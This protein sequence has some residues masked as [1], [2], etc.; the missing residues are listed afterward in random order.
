MRH[1]SRLKRTP[2]VSPRSVGRPLEPEP[3]QIPVVEALGWR[4]ASALGGLTADR[5]T[6][7][8][9]DGLGRLPA[10]D[11]RFRYLEHRQ[12]SPILL[13]GLVGVSPS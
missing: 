13:A 1:Y 11:D 7:D 4:L 6:S 10:N 3:E 9:C 12:S 2:C 8:S 5:P